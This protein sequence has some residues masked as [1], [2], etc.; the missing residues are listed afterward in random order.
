MVV[1]RHRSRVLLMVRFPDVAKGFV[2][3]QNEL[4]VSVP[5]LLQRLYI[6][7]QSHVSTS[8]HGKLPSN[9]SVWTQENRISTG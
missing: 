1:E 5:A 3:S 2:F 4:P 6:H 8:V 9:G 7:V